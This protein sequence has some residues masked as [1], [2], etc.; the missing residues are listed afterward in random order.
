VAW[1]PD[2]DF[3]AYFDFDSSQLTRGARHVVAH[4]A[5]QAARMDT[6]DIYVDGHTDT[7]GSESY[8]DQLSVMRARAV[9]AELV[10]DGV[11]EDIIHIAGSGFDDPLVPT[12][13]GVREGKNRRTVIDL[14]GGEEEAER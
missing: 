6:H 12:P 1:D 13:P 9:R 5:R 4:A 7:V 10:R 14:R 3:V 8:N 11:D 2:R